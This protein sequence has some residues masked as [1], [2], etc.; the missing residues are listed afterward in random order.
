M[1]LAVITVLL[2]Q[3]AE[4]YISLQDFSNDE[5]V[6]ENTYNQS[7]LP[8]SISPFIDLNMIPKGNHEGYI[9]DAHSGGDGSTLHDPEIVEHVH[10]HKYRTFQMHP[11]FIHGRCRENFSYYK[12]SVTSKRERGSSRESEDLENPLFDTVFSDESPQTHNSEPRFESPHLFFRN[13]AGNIIRQVNNVSPTESSPTTI[14]T[15]GR[16]LSKQFGLQNHKGLLSKEMRM[17]ENDRAVEV[18]KTGD[19]VQAQEDSRPV[20]LLPHFQWASRKPRDRS[21]KADDNFFDWVRGFNLDDTSSYDYVT[22]NSPEVD[23]HEDMVCDENTSES[24]TN[25]T[26]HDEMNSIK[27]TTLLAPD[28]VKIHSSLE[29]GIVP[30]ESRW[31]SKRSRTSHPM[32]NCLHISSLQRLTERDEILAPLPSSRSE[33]IQYREP[34]SA[35]RLRTRKHKPKSFH[36]DWYPSSGDETSQEDHLVPL[37]RPGNRD[38]QHKFNGRKRKGYSCIPYLEDDRF[39]LSKFDFEKEASY[40][41]HFSDITPT[42][43]DEDTFYMHETGVRKKSKP[44]KRGSEP[45]HR[46]QGSIIQQIW[47]RQ[48]STIEGSGAVSSKFDPKLF[49]IEGDKEQGKL[50][51]KEISRNYDSLLPCEKYVLFSAWNANNEQTYALHLSQSYIKWLGDASDDQFQESHFEPN[52]YIATRSGSGCK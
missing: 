11:I 12:D 19:H 46:S 42:E 44:A 33:S 1:K 43:P 17:P 5:R 45:M 28:P 22:S 39:V 32:K 2:L 49:P 38:H 50:A 9:E 26:S 47:T 20:D 51:L 31:G 25:L 36:P 48:E 8:C 14:D 23:Q 15:V 52:E 40:I 41:S 7:H 30:S 21:V 35:D 3:Q 6:F 18:L 4:P 13:E 34:W 10:S 24:V 37:F 27:E 16:S 29:D